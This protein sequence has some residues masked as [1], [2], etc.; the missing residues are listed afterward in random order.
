MW[1]GYMEYTYLPPSSGDF[2]L[3]KSSLTHLKVITLLGTTLLRATSNQQVMINFQCF[4][5]D[6]VSPR[7]ILAASKYSHA[8]VDVYE[9]SHYD[10][11]CSVCSLA[12]CCICTQHLTI[13]LCGKLVHSWGTTV[14]VFS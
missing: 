5:S 2:P 9:N 6:M 11:T 1:Q 12:M 8:S 10:R 7:Q 4:T 14:S 3:I 13:S